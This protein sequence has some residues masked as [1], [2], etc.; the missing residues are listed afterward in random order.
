MWTREYATAAA[1]ALR[2]NA[3]HGTSRP[4]A[5]AKANPDAEC[6][7]GNEV[8]DG[9]ATWR[10][11]TTRAP[12]RS[13]R[14]RD[15]MVFT[16]RLTSADDTPM[17]A[18]PAAAARLP[19]RPQNNAS[20]A[21]IPIQIAE[22]LAAFERPR[23]GLSS[24]GDS[25]DATAS[26]TAWSIRER[27]RSTF[28]ACDLIRATDPDM[29][30]AITSSIVGGV[31]AG[32][33]GHAMVEYGTRR[34]FLPAVDGG[35]DLGKATSGIGTGRRASAIL[36]VLLGVAALV[37]AILAVTQ[38]GA[39]VLIGL[40]LC[41]ALL[42]VG[43]RYVVSRRGVP[44]VAGA[45]L[46]AAALDAKIQTAADMLP[47][48]LGPDAR[49]FDLRFT[50]PDGSD[51]P[52]AHLI[53]VSNNPYELDHLGGRGTRARLDAGTLGVVAA[54]IADAKAAEAAG[55]IRSFPG[56]MEWSAPRFDVASG[57]PV[58]IGVDGESMKLDP[59]LAFAS[60]HGALR[61][62]IPMH[63]AGF[64]PAA[65]SRPSM[66]GATFGELLRIAASRP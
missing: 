34:E 58:E 56:W 65:A 66:S 62:R 35:S 21:A 37:T 60:V 30:P 3:S 16:P 23:S 38:A 11:S 1:S 29:S 9:M 20:A 48:M 8:D 46:A 50:G 5:V 10:S 18:T 31:A 28:A 12:A 32:S 25:V 15:A 57:T 40:P 53:L 13:G 49:P 54:R 2:G 22:R 61:V 47:D 51:Y 63:A 44:R 24:A 55:K 43:L 6:P 41:I 52:T 7:E 59:P 4:T 45:V 26:Y 42:V 33:V 64:A 17:A 36:A 27:S 14:L 19:R 39:V